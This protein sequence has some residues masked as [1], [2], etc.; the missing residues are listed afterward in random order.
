MPHLEDQETGVVADEALQS[1]E[2]IFIPTGTDL[3]QAQDMLI[4]E[5]LRQTGGNRTKAASLLGI[6][7]RTLRRK[8]NRDRDN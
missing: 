4:Q 5:A 3:A 8:L 7:L 2:G 1:R 6:S